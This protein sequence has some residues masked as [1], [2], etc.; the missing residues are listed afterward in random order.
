MRGEFLAVLL[1]LVDRAAGQDGDA[2]LLHLGAQMGA[3]V[4]VE[5]AQDVLA[6]IDQRHVGAETGEDAGKLQRDIA[7]ALDH[8]ALR[9]RFQVKHLVRGNHMLDA[10]DR[11]PVVRRAAGRDQHVFCG[12]RL[13]GR[14]PQRVRVLEHRAGLDDAGAGFLHVGGIGGFQPR[15]F[16]VLVGDQGRPVEAR[17]A[18][19][20]SRSPPHPRFRAGYARHRPEAS[21]ARSRGSRRCRPSGI[22]PR[23]SPARHGRRR[24]GRREPRPNLLR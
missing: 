11:L 9:Q 2:L 13:A 24:S 5:A 1:D 4:L 15:D 18:E 10:G 21:S 17:L 22:L 6:A 8:D 12:H 14:E 7:A 23:S 19:W 3:D 20:S 16:P